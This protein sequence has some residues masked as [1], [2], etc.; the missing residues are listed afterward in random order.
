MVIVEAIEVPYR[1]EIPRELIFDSH[2]LRVCVHARLDARVCWSN[3]PALENCSKL[4][5]AKRRAHG[6]EGLDWK[7]SDSVNTH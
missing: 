7:D 1:K 2:A 6:L 4:T 3:P 5:R